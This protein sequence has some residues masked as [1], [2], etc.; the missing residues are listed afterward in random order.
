MFFL[1]IGNVVNMIINHSFS[2]FGMI[3]S[4]PMDSIKIIF[5]ENNILPVL[6]K[7]KIKIYVLFNLRKIQ[8]L[9][10]ILSVI[11]HS[12]LNRIH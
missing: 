7:N 9:I 3:Y 2:V 1:N 10:I 6:T 12:I 11:Y 8:I 4:I 5:K